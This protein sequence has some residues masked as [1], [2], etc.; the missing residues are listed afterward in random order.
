[1]L[2][3]RRSVLQ[4]LVAAAGP[5]NRAGAQ[6]Q[7]VELRAAE[8]AGLFP[9]A[10]ALWAFNGQ[11][12]GPLLKA[13][14]GHEFSL[15]VRNDLSEPIAV[16][17]HG[18]RLPNAMDGTPLAQAPIAPGGVFD[19]SFAPP[20]AGTFWYHTLTN[21]SVQ[22]E[23]G[24]YGMLVVEGAAEQQGFELPM[25][26]DDWKLNEAGELDAASFGDPL[27]A[28]GEGRIGNRFTV[29]G[30][31][32]PILHAP[33]EGHL[34]LRLLNAANARMLKLHIE[35]G[36]LWTIAHDGQPVEPRRLERQPIELA[37]GQRRDISAAPSPLP[38]VLFA[39]TSDGPIELATVE[40][41]GFSPA[42]MPEALHLPP[43]PL[44]DYFNYASLHQVSVTIEGGKG[45][46]LTSA[47]HEGAMLSAGELA[48]RGMTWAVNGQS[49]LGPKPLFSL[50]A[51]VTVA[52]TVD[53]ITRL[54][55][56]L[57]IHGHAARLVE[58]SGRPVADPVWR[59]TFI[60]P[61]LAPVKI[62]FIADNPGK[63]LFASAIAEHFDAGLKAWFEVR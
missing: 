51:G 36:D 34:R 31:E 35:G 49:G 25:I 47:L 18:L 54:S 56:V 43:N 32:R 12:P 22:R 11:I 45:G 16:H 61:P 42:T 40:R 1:M 39:I 21:S 14:Q 44:P 3:S 46:G 5:W 17:W 26:V 27:V 30:K 13:R 6:Q 20:D 58:I 38:L 50:G 15:R 37:P 60:V 41:N 29:N 55:H 57:H 52:F 23:R 24:L 2:A 7:H 59:D 62:L 28:A 63:W 8:S 33:A 10:A 19:Y 53:N 9:F 4:G 48:E